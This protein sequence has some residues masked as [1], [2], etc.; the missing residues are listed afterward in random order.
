MSSLKNGDNIIVVA[1]ERII[2]LVI[3]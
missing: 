2:G 1:W 3:N